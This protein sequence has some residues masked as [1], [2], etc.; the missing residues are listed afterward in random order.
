MTRVR[1]GVLSTASI[2]RLVI[3][4]PAPPT[5][6]RFVAVASRDPDRAGAFAD[7]LGLEASWLLRGAAGLQA[8]D[9]VYVP[10]PVALH[11]EWTVKALEAG[12]HV[13]CEKPLA[14]SAAD[15]AR[16]FDAADGR[17][18]LRRGADVPPPPPDHPGPQAG[19]RRRHRAARLRAGRPQRQR[20]RRHPPLGGTRRR[21]PRRPRLLLRQRHPPVRRRP[22]RVWADQVRD[23]TDGVDLRLAATLH[24]RRRPGPVRR[25]PRPDPPRRT[26]AGRHRGPLTVPDP[27]SRQPPGAVRDGHRELVPVDPDGAFAL[28]DPDHDVYR[29]ELDTVSAALARAASRRSAA[30]TPSPRRPR[31]KP[32]TARPNS[33]RRSP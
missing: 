32:S 30:P 11:T 25:R 8:V 19:R 1:W 3:E 23:G 21:R 20:R 17:P 14:S 26:G 5:T 4:A 9:A 10:L 33:A 12:K 27:G 18:P 29:I 13:L 15:A 2:G 22:G 24:A 16:C 31:S 6:P 7:E 28:T